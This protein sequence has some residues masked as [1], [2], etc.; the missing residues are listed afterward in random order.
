MAFMAVYGRHHRRP[1]VF[2]PRA[3]LNDF[4]DFEISSCYR[5]NR[6]LIE[7]IIFGYSQSRYASTTMRS[8]AITPETQV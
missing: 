4:T 3:T 1:R 5:L 6:F 2:R 8:N 7:D